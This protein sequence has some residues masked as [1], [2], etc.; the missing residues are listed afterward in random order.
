[1]V[2]SAQ[3]ISATDYFQRPEYD[4]HDLIQLIDG[5]VIIGTP[6]IP[7]H[8]AI[9]REILI[10]LTL[11]ARQ[12]GGDAYAAPIE[13]VLN[14]HNVFEPDVLY[15]TPDSNCT[16]GD[17]RLNGAPELVV[18]VLSPGIAKHDRETK[19]R[20]YETYGVREYWIVDPVHE[21][22]EV[23]IQEDSRFLRKGAF[24]TDDTFESS[25]LAKTVSVKAIFN[26]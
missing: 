19:Y 6:P 10:I 13:V 25:V 26:I 8:Q 2:Q 23:W 5:E 1:M 11:I 20:A 18:E 15:L 3:R 22:V 12:T 24:A 21:T 17:K 7:K 14:E 9:V 16:I 4:Q